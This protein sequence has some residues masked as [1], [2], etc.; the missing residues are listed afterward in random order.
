MNFLKRQL[1]LII[2]ISVGLLT[3]FGHFINYEPINDFVDNDATQWFDIIAAFA[4]F[5]G[6]LN[7]LKLQVLKIAYKRKIGNIVYLLFQASFLLFL[8]VSSLEVQIILK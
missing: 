8:L 7:M 2:V 3:L 1:P 4:I 5:L 6:A